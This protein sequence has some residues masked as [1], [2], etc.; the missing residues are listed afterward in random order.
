VSPGL[1][2]VDLGTVRPGVWELRLHA[3]RDGDE[4]ETT[5]RFEVLP[6]VSSR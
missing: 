6:E 5:Q 2:Q 3:R 4:F 1:Y